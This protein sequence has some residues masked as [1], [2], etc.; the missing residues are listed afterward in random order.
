LQYKNIVF[1]Y[2]RQLILCFKQLKRSWTTPDI[3][4]SRNF[5]LNAL[6]D[7][8]CL[9]GWIEILLSEAFIEELETPDKL[10][11]F[12]R[13]A[14]YQYHLEKFLGRITYYSYKYQ[15]G[16]DITSEIIASLAIPR[17]TLTAIVQLMVDERKEK[18]DPTNVINLVTFTQK[19]EQEAEFKKWFIQID[20]L[21]NLQQCYIVLPSL[22]LVLKLGD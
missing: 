11:R 16:E 15:E 14:K 8:G 21:L 13:M 12:G 6:Y 4:N 17:W 22:L 18:D 2:Q 9:F 20:N 10:K 3:V 5:R 1:L 7:F 19:Y